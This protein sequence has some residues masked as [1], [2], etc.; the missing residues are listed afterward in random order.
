MPRFP[1]IERGGPAKAAT[2]AIVDGEAPRAESN[3]RKNRNFRYTDAL[4]RGSVR[5][6]I[7]QKSQLSQRVTFRLV[8]LADRVADYLLFPVTG[9]GVAR[10][11]LANSIL[12]Q[13]GVANES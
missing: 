12:S 8:R 1:R 4:T 7:S 2:A 5:T 6:Q 9:C 13:L 10:Q 11:P 3:F